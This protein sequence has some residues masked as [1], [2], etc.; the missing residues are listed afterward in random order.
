VGAG[1]VR[2]QRKVK[3]LQNDC[4]HRTKRA[5]LLA[6]LEQQPAEVKAVRKN[7]VDKIYE[8]HVRA[9]DF[10]ETVLTPR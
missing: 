6:N 3:V 4:L 10:A 8:A 7:P 5:E 2:G 9:V 1:G